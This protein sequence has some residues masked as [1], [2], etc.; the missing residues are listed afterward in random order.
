MGRRGNG[1]PCSPVEAE[2]RNQFYQRVQRIIA[3]A[4]RETERA[5]PGS[6]NYGS[7]AKRATSQLWALFRPEAHVSDEAWRV[8]VLG[9]IGEEA[10][11]ALAQPDRRLPQSRLKEGL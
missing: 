1:R 7:V 11:E 6:L 5:H 8:F 10:L 2:A 9:V 3:A 4:V